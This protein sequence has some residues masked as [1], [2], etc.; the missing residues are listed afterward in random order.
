MQELFNEIT[1]AMTEFQVNSEKFLDKGNKSAGV[2]SRRAS[3]ALT[4]MLKEWRQMTVKA[5]T[6]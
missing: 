2:R 4:K 6:E 5:D 3:R 1:V